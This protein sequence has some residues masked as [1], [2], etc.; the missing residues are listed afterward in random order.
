M[1]AVRRG[2]GSALAV[3]LLLLL[4]PAS[5]LAHMMSM[6]TGDLTV[7]GARAH[8]VLRM[9]D[10]EIAHVKDPERSLFEHLRFTGGGGPARLAAHACRSA[11]AEG[12]YIC[13]AD[14]EFP[15]EVDL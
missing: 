11:P 3:F 12:S 5:L 4:L 2:L 14:Y 7:E 10:Y 9:P 13:E 8:Y 15:G 6:S 1:R